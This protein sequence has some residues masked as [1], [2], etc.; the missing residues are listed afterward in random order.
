MTVALPK[1]KGSVRSMILSGEGIVVRT[2]RGT[3]SGS[4]P[5]KFAASVQ[6]Y[7]E[8][9]DETDLVDAH[10]DMVASSHYRN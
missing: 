1:V 5:P 2:T 9:S 4:G 6:F 10:S 7:F 3:S 8:K